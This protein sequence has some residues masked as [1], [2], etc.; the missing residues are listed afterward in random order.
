MLVKYI[1]QTYI[2]SICSKYLMTYLCFIWMLQKVDLD[3]AYTSM[4][5]EYV[6]KC[7]QMFNTYVCKCFVWMLHIFAL[8]F[9]CFSAIFASV[10]DV[11]FKCFI[12]LFFILQLLHLNISKVNRVLHMGYACGKRL[13]A[14]ITSG[15]ARAYLCCTHPRA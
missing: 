10:S 4:L 7:F 2:L 11:C 8:V 1:H 3:I 15:A 13:T 14:R 6:F 5:Q 9:K 12:C